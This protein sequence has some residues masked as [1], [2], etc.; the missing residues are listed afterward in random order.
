MLV[1]AQGVEN[2]AKNLVN[3]HKIRNLPI[4]LPHALLLPTFL[5]HVKFYLRIESCLEAFW[6]NVTKKQGKRFRPKK[7]VG[8]M[9]NKI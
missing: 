8:A 9:V 4:L 6:R 1:T 2:Q 5:E 7:H 3:L